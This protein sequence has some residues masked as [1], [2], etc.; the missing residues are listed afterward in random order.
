[1]ADEL[2]NVAPAAP[3]PAP[4]TPAEPIKAKPTITVGLRVVSL[5]DRSNTPDEWSKTADLGLWVLALLARDA[6]VDRERSPYVRGHLRAAREALRMAQLA[7]TGREETGT[8]LCCGVATDDDR[9]VCYACEEQLA[10]ETAAA[11]DQPEA[12]Q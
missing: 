6:D 1:M 2:M 12:G 3:S 7:M 10:D 4:E 11:T 8:C 9:T 5:D